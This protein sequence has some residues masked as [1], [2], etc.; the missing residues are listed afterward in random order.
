M[1]FVWAVVVI[2]SVCFF[3]GLLR[4]GFRGTADTFREFG[5]IASGYR[6]GRKGEAR[7]QIGL[8]IISALIV[9]AGIGLLCLIAR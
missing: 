2:M 7:F 4:D 5:A 6:E 3:V 8:W 1:F 9:S